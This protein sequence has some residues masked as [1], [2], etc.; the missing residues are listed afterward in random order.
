MSKIFVMLYCFHS[1]NVEWKIGVLSYYVDSFMVHIM[2]CITVSEY[3]C[4][5]WPPRI[6]SVCSG[7]NTFIPF[8]SWLVTGF[9]TKVSPWVQLVEVELFNLSEHM[10]SFA[11]LITFSFI[12]TCVFSFLCSVWIVNNST[13]EK[14]KT[15]NHLNTNRP[16]H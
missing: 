16:W 3:L 10:C 2:N 4:H 11:V 13:N 5:G 14:K 7:H 9:L 15:N 6:C 1:R 8:L 12:N